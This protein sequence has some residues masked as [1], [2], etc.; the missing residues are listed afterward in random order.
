ML[1]VFVIIPLSGRVSFSDGR[2]RIYLL[3]L[4]H[5]DSVLFHFQDEL[6]SRTDQR[7]LTTRNWLQDLDA[8]K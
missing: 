1:T 5:Q 4:F 3:A 7:R 8:S 6:L 2:H